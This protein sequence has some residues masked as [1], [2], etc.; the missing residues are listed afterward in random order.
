LAHTDS[1]ASVVVKITKSSD[2]DTTK[3]R[4]LEDNLQLEASR[5]SRYVVPILDS[6]VAPLIYSADESKDESEH[7]YSV[8]PHFVAGTL[9][10]W[11]PGPRETNQV[12]KRKDLL[13]SIGSVV[14]AVDAFGLQGGIVNRDIKSSNILMRRGDAYVTDFSTA[15]RSGQKENT[16]GTIMATASLVAPEQI[17]PHVDTYNHST[18]IWYGTGL[19]LRILDGEEI[20]LPDID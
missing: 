9:T 12:Y 3:R 13:R 11:I 8:T 17:L 10:R 5:F 4:R 15:V 20:I 1:G 2:E 6:G 14:D 7:F 18:D 16:S 19:I